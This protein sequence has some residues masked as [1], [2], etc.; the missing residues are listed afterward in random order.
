MN[1]ETSSQE[2]LPLTAQKFFAKCEANKRNLKMHFFIWAM[3]ETG[4]VSTIESNYKIIAN[5]AQ[6]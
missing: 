3:I 4:E 2:V 1:I 5:K 6:N